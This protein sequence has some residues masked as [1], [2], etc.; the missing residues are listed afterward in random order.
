MFIRKEKY[1]R[2]FLYVGSLYY[3]IGAVAH[4]FGYTIFPFYD[5]NLYSPYHDTVIALAAIVLSLS[6]YAAGR[7]P[8]KNIDM[9]NVI[10]FACILAILFSI[11]IIW[12][13]DFVQLGAPAK[14][15]QTIVE[16]II[17]IVYTFILVI[18]RPKKVT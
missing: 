3:L 2:L 16:M 13:I 5:G 1:L 8:K 7:N 18:L 17:L 12:K 11:G 6:L 15:M 9:L 4:L 14:K 10:I